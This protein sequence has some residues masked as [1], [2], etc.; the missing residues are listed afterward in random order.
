MFTRRVAIT[1][2]GSGTSECHNSL[3]IRREF[4]RVSDMSIC[5]RYRPERIAA[6]GFIPKREPALSSRIFWGAT[7]VELG[8]RVPICGP[9]P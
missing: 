1:A 9:V 4:A 2:T 7:G 6:V 3:Y 8:V 5:S